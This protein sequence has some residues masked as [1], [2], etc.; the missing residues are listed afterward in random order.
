VPLKIIPRATLGTCALGCQCLVHTIPCHDR[1]HINIMLVL[2]S[3]IDSS[4]SHATSSGGACNSSNIDIEEDI[5]VVEDG[6]IGVNE[7]AVTGIIEEEIA[8]AINFPDIKS[9]PNEVSYVCVCLL[10]DTFYQCPAMSVVSVMSVFLATSNVSTFGNENV[11][12]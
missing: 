10:L 2:Q 4:E 11:L 1:G 12:V 6:F 9:E 8:E 3:R 5:D 7:E